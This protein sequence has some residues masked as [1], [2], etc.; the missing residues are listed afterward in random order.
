MIFTPDD[1]SFPV[2]GKMRVLGFLDLKQKG[3]R[4]SRQ[5]IAKLVAR[6]KFPAPIKLG[7]QSVA[8]VEAEIDEW[9]AARIRERDEQPVSNAHIISEIDPPSGVCIHQTGTVKASGTDFNPSKTEIGGPRRRRTCV[10]GRL[11]G[12]HEVKRDVTP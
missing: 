10:G 1:A 5:W 3:I 2:G 6:G 7:E 4:F 8:F 12:R 9:L 11:S